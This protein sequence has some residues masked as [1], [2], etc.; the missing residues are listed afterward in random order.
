MDSCP[1]VTFTHVKGHQDDEKEVNELPL[2]AQ[3]NV[4]ADALAAE[5]D[6]NNI[7]N[8]PIIEGTKVIVRSTYGTLTARYA[9]NIRQFI[10]CRHI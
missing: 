9:K 8:A 2:E 5:V 10:N 4:E 7:S 1:N 3:L 6:N